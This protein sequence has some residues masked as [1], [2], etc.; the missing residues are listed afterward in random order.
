VNTQI[1]LRAASARLA[2]ACALAV[3]L[4]AL[5][6]PA[7]TA[8]AQPP[9][10][11]VGVAPTPAIKAPPAPTRLTAVL[12]RV[13][14]L[15]GS[16]VSVNGYLRP[17]GAGRLVRLERRVGRRWRTVDTDRT[18]ASGRYSL[19]YRANDS[20][21]VRVSFAG[22]A[23]HTA[24]SKGAG[25]ITAY[26]PALASWYALYGGRLA[27]GG[28]LGYSSLVVAHRSLPCGTRVTVRY[29]G[30]VV[31]ARVM[32][33]GPFSGHREFDLAGGVARRLGFQ[34]VGTVW[35]TR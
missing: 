34:G 19:R 13:H 10:Q 32:D 23:A 18:A 16:T 15:V 14:V 28:R 33:R 25:R 26:R 4:L 30:R 6:P 9:A 12:R 3:S 29:R 1:N 35:V 22:D 21:I 17:R 2:A 11:T 20:A 31:H 24:T 7:G 8:I 5:A 27:C